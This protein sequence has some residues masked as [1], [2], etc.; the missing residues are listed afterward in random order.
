MRQVVGGSPSTDERGVSHVLGVV[1]VVAVVLVAVTATVGF[2]VAGLTGGT[3][4][5]SETAV[6]RDLVA[7][8]DAVDRA[9]VHSDTASE[10][11]TVALSMRELDAGDGRVAVD[12]RAGEFELLVRTDGEETRVVDEPLGL[13]EYRSQ[14]GDARIAYQSGLV[15]SSPDTESTPA[16]LRS[17][18]FDHRIDDGGVESLTVHVTGVSGVDRLH[19]E[20]RASTTASENRYPDRVL[21]GDAEI[22]VRIE[23][24]YS[25]GWAAAL[26]GTLPADAD[27]SHDVGGNEVEAVYETPAEGMFL[28]AT[29][30]EVSLDGR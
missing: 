1:L 23:S 17:N 20:M 24:A 5:L 19:R 18:A 25:E 30:H 4:E 7:F 12:D 26:A 2:G 6:E 16:V 14:D 22:V 15:F 10:T 13:V 28:H 9:T 27:V 21:D 29:H 8:A 11:A 3:S